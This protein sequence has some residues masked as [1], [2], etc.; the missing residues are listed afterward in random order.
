VKGFLDAGWREKRRDFDAVDSEQ[1]GKFFLSTQ[2]RKENCKCQIVFSK[3]KT[4]SIPG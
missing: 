4:P 2:R 1:S 3:L